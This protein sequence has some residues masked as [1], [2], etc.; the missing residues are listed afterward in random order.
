MLFKFRKFFNSKNLDSDKNPV[1]L[2]NP[3]N[4]GFNKKAPLNISRASISYIS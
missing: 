1:D 2:I 3:L 4:S